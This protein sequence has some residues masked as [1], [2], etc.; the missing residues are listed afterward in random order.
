MFNLCHHHSNVG[1]DIC[2]LHRIL[3]FC[4]TLITF[5]INHKVTMILHIK[6][7][8]AKIPTKKKK[9]KLKYQDKIT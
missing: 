1:G 8:E 4:T 9:A 2:F 3:F 6:H 5:V 7:T